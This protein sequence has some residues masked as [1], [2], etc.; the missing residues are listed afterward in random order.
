MTTISECWMWLVFLA[1]IA[2]VLAV[3]LFLLGGRKIHRVCTRE[4]LS[5]TL[6]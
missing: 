1:F 2:A 4:E 6:T 5:W 3:D